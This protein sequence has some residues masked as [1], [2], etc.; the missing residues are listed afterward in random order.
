MAELGMTQ[1]AFAG[2]IGAPWE[3]FKKWLLPV[4][5]GGAR[6]MPAVAWALVR[7][8]LDHE[9]LKYSLQKPSGKTT[10]KKS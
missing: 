3:T 9:R 4:E 8:V 2:R 10:V 7:E 1:K 5:A 6:E